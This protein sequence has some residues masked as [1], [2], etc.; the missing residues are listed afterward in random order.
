M[1]HLKNE[2]VFHQIMNDFT[3]THT[4]SCNSGV[5]VCVC[6]FSPGQRALSPEVKLV[7]PLSPK[8]GRSDEGI[9][10]GGVVGVVSSY[11]NQGSY[12]KRKGEKKTCL[13]VHRPF[14][15]NNQRFE[16]FMAL[17]LSFLV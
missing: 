10:G 9:E 14:V 2:K 13:V 5:C 8:R 3:I 1:S 16:P 15:L 4:Y 17:I 12:A 11:Q 7:I 6:T